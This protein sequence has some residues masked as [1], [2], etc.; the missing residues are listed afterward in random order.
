MASWS[1]VLPRVN[2]LTSQQL[3]S[4]F[5]VN[6]DFICHFE[7]TLSGLSSSFVHSLKVGAL[8]TFGNPVNKS[9]LDPN[10]LTPS[11]KVPIWVLTLSFIVQ[12]F[13]KN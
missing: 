10:I 11:E 6:F 4:G 2:V 12:N 8:F 13:L 5:S 3:H 9:F 1:C 7:F